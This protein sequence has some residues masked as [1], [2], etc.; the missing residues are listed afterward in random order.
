M[1]KPDPYYSGV[2]LLM[3][4]SGAI[5]NQG[6]FDLSSAQNPVVY[7]GEPAF[8][9]SIK[10][11]YTESR[12]FSGTAYMHFMSTPSLQ[13]GTGDFTIEAWVYLVT[14]SQENVICSKGTG[15]SDGLFFAFDPDRRLRLTYAN[16]ATTRSAAVN[17][18]VWHHVAC[19][20]AS[21]TTRVFL[22]GA[23]FTSTTLNPNLNDTGGFRIGRGR[24]SSSN[25]LSGH[26]QD[27]RVTKGVARYTAD[28][29][30]PDQL[31]RL[32][33]GGY[34]AVDAR[35]PLKTLTG[36][37]T[38]NSGAPIDAVRIRGWVDRADVLSVTPDEDGDWSASIPP[39]QYDIT[40]LADGCAP[41]C[42]GPYTVDP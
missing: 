34:I 5:S 32:G 13:M 33:P 41:V 35:L 10:K 37:A 7:Y 42:H 15:S 22:N 8:S 11:F 16:T 27:L 14:G 29:T 36:N 17:T 25:Y 24:G 26:L 9:T 20:R 40:Y 38:R 18:G 2:S 12:V 28:F 4:F 39:G 1:L 21:G 3:P 23:Q 30:P 6:T 19:S 31:I